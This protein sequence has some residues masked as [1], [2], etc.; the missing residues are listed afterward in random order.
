MTAA[1]NPV[2]RFLGAP[3]TIRVCRIG[4]GLVMLAAALGKIGDPGTFATQI[5]HYRL[6]PVA[7]ENLVAIVLP[8]VELIAGL[9]LVLGVSARSGAWLSAAMMM[10]FTA[11]VSLAVARN[12]DIEC[13]CFGT[14]DASH[15][16]G[17]KLAENLLLTGAALVAS[18]RLR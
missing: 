13:G 18:I 1:M 15:V 10:V 14:A 7:A 8:W 11:A 12:L 6:I 17:R 5:H 16:G 9:A 3:A 2:M 4:I